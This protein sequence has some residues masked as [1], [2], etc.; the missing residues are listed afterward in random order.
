MSSIQ[1]TVVAMVCAALMPWMAAD[2]AAQTTFFVTSAADAGDTSPG[3]GVCAASGGACTLRAAI[4]ES[5]A[6]P[7]ADIIEFAIGS[8][9]QTI[10]LGST[11]PA[12]TAPA[13]VDG[14]TQPGFSGT[15]IIVIN[16]SG[17][18]G[19]TVTGGN[20]MLRGLVIINA[21]GHGVELQG[22][23]GNV[24]EGNYIGMAADGVTP[25]AN[26]GHGIVVTSAP[27]NRIGGP[28]L[29]QRNLISKNTAKG[30]GGG[31]FLVGGGGNVIQGNFIGTDI[32]GMVEHP[33]EARGI[34]LSGS[35]NN[36]I[37]GPGPGEGNLIA[38]NRA[39]G[40]RMLG[41]SSHNTVQNN[42]LGVNRTV[43]AFIPN[44]R[45]VQ[46]RAGDGNKVLGNVI[47][48]NT[49][50]GV[51][52]WGGTNTLVE[53]NSIAFNGFGPIGDPQEAGYFGVWVS[54]GTGNRVVSNQIWGNYHIGINLNN[55]AITINDAGDGDGGG[56]NAQNY[57]ALTSA[58]RSAANTTIMGRLNSS[59]NG[60]FRVQFFANPACDS[61]GVGEGQHF[62]GETSVTTDA[63]GFAAI[64][65]VVGG[66]LPAGWVVT[67][68]ATDAAGNT[69][70]FSGCTTVR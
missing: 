38:G 68:T 37:G 7:G 3:N 54:S 34:A 17:S 60:T 36:L 59:P 33:N 16:A 10:A 55:D 18:G 43:T 42:F 35:S 70:E 57:P 11:L 50:D 49:Y 20:T 52:I 31:I 27:N 63:S 41:G 8:G 15:P 23:G 56:N 26:T 67:S 30:A 19:L 5:N 61:T 66:V 46:I 14:W 6:L 2:A 51:L 39:T 29:Q 40:V 32:T 1:K 44:D 64:A 48:G 25:A 47:V 24:L 22:L 21:T 53:G 28:S 13:T 69:S 9:P 65:T 58:T 45:G 62:V 4:Q 12:I